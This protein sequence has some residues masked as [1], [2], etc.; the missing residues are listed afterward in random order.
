MHEQLNSNL[1][2][3]FTPNTK[4][5]ELNTVFVRE[6]LINRTYRLIAHSTSDFD[7]RLQF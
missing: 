3:Y 2:E 4:L 6:R 7:D 5:K 1:F